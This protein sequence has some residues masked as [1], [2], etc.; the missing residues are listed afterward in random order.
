MESSKS[1]AGLRKGSIVSRI[2]PR[3]LVILLAVAMLGCGGGRPAA[4]EPA[5]RPNV[6]FI[7]VDDLGYADLGCYGARD[8]RTP[9]IDRLARE[10]VLLT[11]AYAAAC[12]C[13]PTRVALMTGRYPQR[14]GFDWVIDYHER[15]RGLPTKET[16]LPR[17]MKQAGYAT[18]MFGKWHLGY[19]PEYAPNAHGFDEF[20]GFLA[21]DLDYYAHREARG[22]PGLYE[23]TR[24]VVQ[25]GYLTDLLT[26]RAA[27]YLRAH[28]SEPFFLYL[29]YNAPHYPFQRPGQPN[30]FRN[31]R[32]YGPSYGTRGDY[33]QMVEHLDLSIGRVLKELHTLGLDENTLVIFTNDNGG[34]RLSNNGPLFHGKF[35]LWE[36][37]IR[38][39]FIARWPGNIP[40]QTTSRQPIITMDLTATLLKFAGVNPAAMPPLDGEDILPVLLGK[41]APRERTFY[42]RIRLPGE[43]LGQKAV[44]RGQWKYVK[45]RR[46]DLLFNLEKD[47]GE[48]N[49]LTLAQPKILAELQ[50]ALEDW[51][52]KMP[53]MKDIEQK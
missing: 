15:D 29:A 28:K 52:K 50:A 18:G 7:L 36:G 38:V 6:L 20:F 26:D 12:V 17:L 11:D 42:W 16:C 27:G 44:R 4:P 49:N 41:E 5:K 19:R 51:D 1:P 22:E 14:T 34:E 35:T 46:S 53:P 37:G 33:I 23:N 9:N 21:A 45:D 25:E 24:L 31:G 13:T 3:T 39:P 47:I 10:G 30:D 48:R 32:T 40:A 8:I 43:P 2:H